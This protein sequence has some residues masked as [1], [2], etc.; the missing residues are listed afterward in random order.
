LAKIY[1]GQI[2]S[3]DDTE[4]TSIQSTANKGKLKALNIKN[5]TPAYR[6]AGSGTSDNLAGYLEATTHNFTQSSDWSVATGG[7]T[8]RGNSYSSG[9]NLK[10]GVLANAGSIGY[11]DLKDA[12]SGVSIALLRNEAGQYYAAD[13]KRSNTFLSE[14]TNIGGNGNVNIDWTTNVSGGYNASLFTYA[15]VNTNSSKSVPVSVKGANVK[16]FLGYVLSTCGPAI[17][18]G[19]GY[20][21]I[22]GAVRTKALAVINYIK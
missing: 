18:Y 17:S 10:T 2:T 15:V 16:K 9:G 14:Q 13:A 21:P 4:I 1:K 5:I 12:L 19:I 6:A 11:V 8:P 20:T 22:Q 7:G 3:W